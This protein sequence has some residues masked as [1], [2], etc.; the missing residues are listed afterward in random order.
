M[1]KNPKVPY[2]SISNASDYFTLQTTAK[3]F[4]N[5]ANLQFFFDNYNEDNYASIL[6]RFSLENELQIH[7]LKG[8]FDMIVGEVVMLKGFNGEYE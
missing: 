7:A 1:L 5:P 8:Y 3:T 4:M 2:I 6:K